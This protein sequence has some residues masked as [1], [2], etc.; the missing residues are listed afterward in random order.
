MMAKKLWWL[1]IS[2]LPFQLCGQIISVPR[3]AVFYRGLENEI[4]IADKNHPCKSLKFT[5]SQG[6]LQDLGNCQYVYRPDSA[7]WVTFTLVGKDK[8]N[9]SQ[10][11]TYTYPVL[12]VP[13]PII[14]VGGV[15]GGGSISKQKLQIQPGIYTEYDLHS[16]ALCGMRA[17]ILTYSILIT[18][19]DSVIHLEN[20]QGPA[21]SRA[22]RQAFQKLKSGDKLVVYNISSR[23]PGGIKKLHPVEFTVFDQV[24]LIIGPD[25]IL[26]RRLDNLITVKQDANAWNS[27]AI[28]ADHG[29]VR[30]RRT[31]E[32]TYTTDSLAPVTFTVLNKKTGQS[33]MFKYKVIDVPSAVIVEGKSDPPVPVS[34][35]SLLE[36]KDITSQLCLPQGLAA[37]GENILIDTFYID[38]SRNDSLIHMEMTAGAAF[39]EKTKK[40]LR[41]LQSG[42]LILIV[43]IRVRVSNG[44]SRTL[45]Q[46]L[47]W[48]ISE[49]SSDK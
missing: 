5:A 15:R 27:I 3:T 48:I 4:N 40:V 45:A 7:G 9:K 6:E 41:E 21:F 16:Y 23:G 26:Y 31:G 13:P 30:Q 14:F 1:V 2:Y 17:D 24:S 49:P 42:D 37:R 34:R 10:T 32:Y 12:E 19:K 38:I 47:R 29:I 33:F 46:E 44:L 25:T 11:T 43:D 36:L 20:I 8:S 35:E 39:S 22:T 28:T 18:R